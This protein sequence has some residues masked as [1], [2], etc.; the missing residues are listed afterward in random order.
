M[1]CWANELKASSDYLSSIT[2]THAEQSPAVAADSAAQV[3]RHK[4]VLS[5]TRQQPYAQATLFQVS[6]ATYKDRTIGMQ[7]L[8][9]R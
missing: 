1:Q 3:V 8:L 7:A 4:R 5:Y 6:K 9:Y 2:T